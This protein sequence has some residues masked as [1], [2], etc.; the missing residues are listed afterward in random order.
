MKKLYILVIALIF[1]QIYSQRSEEAERKSMMK[2]ELDLYSKMIDYNENPNTA[3]YDL[4][5]QRL[6]LELNPSQQFVAG[7]VTNHFIAKENMSAIYFDLANTLTVSEVKYHGTALIFTQLGTKEL[8]IDFPAALS[9]GTL[10]SLSIKYS[11]APSTVGSAGDA[12]TVST[13]GGTPVLFTL[14]EP[15]GAQEWF[16]TKQSMND[17]IEKVDI[18]ITT[19]S[20]YSVAS[21]GKLLAE[22]LVTG[23][24]KL[25][26]WQTNYP[27]PAYLIALGI[28]NYTKINDTMGTPPFPFVNYLYPST[29]SNTTIMSNIA[30][31]KTVMDT[32]EQY[33]GPYPYRNEKYGHMQFSW[34]GGM[35]HA[36]MSSMGA[37]SRGI[38]AH[39]LAHQWF[40]DKVTCGAWNDIWLNEG[41][42][43]FG[44]HLANEKLLMNSAAFQNYLADEIDYIT[45]SAGGS[46]YVA[47]SALGDSN[48]L[49]SGRLT[50]A[51]GGY[52]LRMMKWILG[53]DVFYAA[54]K[55]YHSRPN[56]AYNYA[57]TEDFK[58][59]V[60]QSTGKDFTG[61]FNDWIYGQG[62]PTYQI[63]WNQT[64]DQVLRFKVSQTQSNASVSF[65]ELPLPIKVIGTGGQV[66][67]V[68][69]DNTANNQNFEKIVGF[70]VASVQ[71]NYENQIIQKNSTVTKDTSILAVANISKEAVKIYPNPVNN[72][73]SV[74][75]ITVD[76]PFEIY[77]MDGKMV[78]TGKYSSKEKI[79]VG[80]LPKGIYVLKIA[81]QNLK[82]IKN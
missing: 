50:Y 20:Q 22:T 71:F 33:F 64:A 19:P 2:G 48:T 3:N 52:V 74:S 36:T 77:S 42:A 13:Q 49:F 54:L 62:Y 1:G 81:D 63:K 76:Q 12:F 80:N 46:V 28:T 65:F 23:G 69:L 38:I 18:K 58:A 57:R 30:W 60:L 67:Y 24:K 75:G 8:K 34:G 5:Y 61:F 40:G 35:E 4:R 37:W 82:F 39:E 56:L 72:Q 53:D 70:P 68:V 43:T 14:S 11:G 47:T 15:Y 59:S 32:F 73:L 21:N 31:T 78:K 26:F 7:T 25:T 41:F 55:D 44:E 66:A 27:I 17:K 10:D 45:S 29:T 9:T 6:E 16:P 79:E 51:K